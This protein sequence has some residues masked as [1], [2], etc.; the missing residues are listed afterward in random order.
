[1]IVQG[2]LNVVGLIFAGLAAALPDVDFPFA[3]SL[4]DFAVTVGQYANGLDGF[5]PVSEMAVAVTWALTVY[6]PFVVTFVIVRWVFQHVPQ[7]GGK[8]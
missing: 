8:S 4:E 3:G 5:L 6:L 1:M 2:L 7:I